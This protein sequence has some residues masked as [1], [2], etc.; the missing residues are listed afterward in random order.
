MI[1]SI[2]D[3]SFFRKRYSLKYPSRD[4]ITKHQEEGG[5][6]DNFFKNY[7]LV[8]KLLVTLSWAVVSAVSSLSSNT[9]NWIASQGF[10]EVTIIIIQKFYILVKFFARYNTR[11]EKY[12]YFDNNLAG[13]IYKL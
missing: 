10:E 2:M 1:D 5:E 11:D 9:F 8:R 4:L 13:E 3:H 7:T 6:H 12:L